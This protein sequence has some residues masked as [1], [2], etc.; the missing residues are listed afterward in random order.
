[1][2]CIS[3]QIIVDDELAAYLRIIR[4]HRCLQSARS[5]ICTRRPTAALISRAAMP[6]YSAPVSVARAL[7]ACVANGEH[8]R[9]QRRR[10]AGIDNSRLSAVG[11]VDG[12]VSSH[13]CVCEQLA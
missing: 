2:M 4:H 3:Q 7:P 9:P 10:V 13:A 5:R 12:A 6:V 11:G 8:G 1:M